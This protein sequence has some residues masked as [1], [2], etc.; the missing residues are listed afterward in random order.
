MQSAFR[1]KGAT[2]AFRTHDRGLWTQ[3]GISTETKLICLPYVC[4]LLPKWSYNEDPRTTQIKMIIN[5][6]L[7]WVQEDQIGSADYQD[8]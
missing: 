8:M 3:H 2:N 5:T 1:L 6:V 7:V 4:V